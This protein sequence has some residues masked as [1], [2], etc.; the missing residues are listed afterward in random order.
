PGETVHTRGS[1]NHTRSSHTA[2]RPASTSADGTFRID[3]G[4]DQNPALEPVLS[5]RGYPFSASAGEADLESVADSPSDSADFSPSGTSNQDTS[6]SSHQ[7]SSISIPG[8]L[9]RNATSSFVMSGPTSWG[10]NLARSMISFVA[11]PPTIQE[12]GSARRDL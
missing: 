6:I 9:P 10:W 7:A 5:E 8:S 1:H 12:S 4:K 2:D 3:S 11:Y